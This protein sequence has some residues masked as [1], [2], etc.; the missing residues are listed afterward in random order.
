MTYTLFILKYCYIRL[1][2]FELSNIEHVNTPADITDLHLFYSFIVVIVPLLKWCLC[3]QKLDPQLTCGCMKTWCCLTWLFLIPSINNSE[4]TNTREKNKKRFCLDGKWQQILIKMLR[5]EK[6]SLGH[7]W[8]LYVFVSA[9]FYIR[10]F[11]SSFSVF[12]IW[13]VK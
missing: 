10:V 1:S 3:R 11:V 6:T 5:K 12:L 7:F 9:A 13:G 4:F 2:M 8:M